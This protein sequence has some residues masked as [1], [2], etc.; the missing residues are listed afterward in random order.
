MHLEQVHEEV[1]AAMG[2]V[3][4]QV[5][6][7]CEEA[8]HLGQ[9]AV[10]L[11][12]DTLALL[13]HTPPAATANSAS[14][15]THPSLPSVATTPQTEKMDPKSD[16]TSSPRS[17]A[18]VVPQEEQLGAGVATPHSNSSR[19]GARL[20]E[21]ATVAIM[22]G[23]EEGGGG[24][25]AEKLMRMEITI[26]QLQATVAEIAGLVRGELMA[27]RSGNAAAGGA[28]THFE[29]SPTH[30]EPIVAIPYTYTAQPDSSLKTPLHPGNSRGVTRAGD[31]AASRMADAGTQLQTAEAE[32]HKLADKIDLIRGS[33]SPQAGEVEA[34]ETD[35]ALR[36]AQQEA[37]DAQLK[38]AQL[39]EWVAQK[40]PLA[41]GGGVSSV[42]AC[43]VDDAVD[44]D[45]QSAHVDHLDDYGGADVIDGARDGA[46][47]TS[48]PTPV[49]PDTP[50]PRL[51]P[52]SVKVSDGREEGDVRQDGG[53]VG[54]RRRS[55]DTPTVDGGPMGMQTQQSML[56]R[57]ERLSL[58]SSV[59]P[60]AASIS[61]TRS[62][63]LSALGRSGRMDEGVSA[64]PRRGMSDID[65]PKRGIPD[66]H[67]RVS[68][69]GV[70]AQRAPPAPSM[71]QVESDFRNPDHDSRSLRDVLLVNER[72]HLDAMSDQVLPSIAPVQSTVSPLGGGAGG[73]GMGMEDVDALDV[74]AWDGM[75]GDGSDHDSELGNNLVPDDH[76]LLVDTSMEDGGGW[77]REEGV[78]EHSMEGEEHFVAV[79]DQF[80]GD[81]TSAS[82]DISASA[83]LR[84][85]VGGG[86]GGGR[87]V[88]V[89]SGAF[90]VD[91]PINI[92]AGHVQLRGERDAV[93]MGRWVFESGASGR[94]KTLKLVNLP[95]APPLPRIGTPLT[96]PTLRAW[97]R[98]MNF[99]QIYMYM[100]YTNSY[101]YM[102]VYVYKYIH[103]Y[104]Q[105]VCKCVCT[106]IYIYTDMYSY[107]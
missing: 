86:G 104:M 22:V 80:D 93:V 106:N 100:V 88:C 35:Q 69:K 92:G 10:L 29:P 71:Q 6:S 51:P 23:F 81:G 74:D 59:S 58:V 89:G 102:C 62:A 25:S 41:M 107:I 32:I 85:L 52:R 56:Q 4:Q 5:E 16:G 14:S 78:G 75:G 9:S 97:V 66:S 73:D 60:I 12:S 34:V 1:L 48:P 27:T 37:T 11:L 43:D 95:S 65:T 70:S 57:G 30:V 7:M 8:V 68:G 17:T 49:A 84:R 82:A 47:Y 20:S 99:I 24:T 2:E 61:R 31:G 42:D 45:A 94:L 38:L 83:L 40:W 26:N 55:P 101:I 54:S 53:E 105:K 19:S 50:P 36:A 64:T 67:A 28:P 15:T 18:P 3:Q 72:L 21:S 79:P 39:R 44:H 91:A 87:R 90:M 13:T 33:R 46:R 96:P 77:G 76:T 98:V 103:I 63:E